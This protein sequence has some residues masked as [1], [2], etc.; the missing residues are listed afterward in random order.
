[1]LIKLVTDLFEN[2][3]IDLSIRKRSP[4]S[5]VNRKKCRTSFEGT[6][7]LYNFTQMEFSSCGSTGRLGPSLTQCR[8]YY[9]H[10]WVQN[11]KYFTMTSGRQGSGLIKLSDISR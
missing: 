9:K 7:A 4:S 5:P 6:E 8:K 2:C 10:D 11:D 1:M 3:D